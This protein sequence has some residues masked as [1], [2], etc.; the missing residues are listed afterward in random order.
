MSVFGAGD[1]TDTIKMKVDKI[2]SLAGNDL[3]TFTATLAKAGVKNAYAYNVTV[4]TN[5]GEKTVEMVKADAGAATFDFRVPAEACNIELTD[6][7]VAV[8]EE[9]L[10]VSK[11]EV[12]DGYK[13][14]VTFNM[15]VKQGTAEPTFT[16]AGSTVTGFTIA[17]N[18]VTIDTGANITAGSH[19]VGIDHVDNL[20]SAKTAANKLAGTTLGNAVVA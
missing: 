2:T 17:G 20:V 16:V 11:I 18:T 19:A 3:V 12:V 13:V 5:V 9:N 15:A 14:V 6:V 7:T 10:A 1:K 8:A 4:K